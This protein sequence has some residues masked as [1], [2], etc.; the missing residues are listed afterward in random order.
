MN[1]NI[2]FYL[3]PTCHKRRLA[4]MNISIFLFLVYCKHSLDYLTSPQ[5]APFL[6]PHYYCFCYI[7]ID[8][9]YMIYG[10]QL[11]CCFKYFLH[12]VVAQNWSRCIISSAK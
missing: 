6:N 2:Q 11:P 3:T 8:T 4:A 10:L 9:K 5:Q 7:H 1:V 12:T